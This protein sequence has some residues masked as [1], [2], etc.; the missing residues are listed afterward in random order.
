MNVKKWNGIE[1]KGKKR[2]EKEILAIYIC[3][4]YTNYW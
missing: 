3:R 4:I 2:K 1:T